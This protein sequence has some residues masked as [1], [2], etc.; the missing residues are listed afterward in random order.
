RAK[1]ALWQLC[2]FDVLWVGA[3]LVVLA[4]VWTW[5]GDIRTQPIDPQ[6]ADMLVVIR[7]GIARFLQWKNPYTIY[8]VPW[9]APLPYGPVLWLPFA[10][11][12]V[13]HV[14]IRVV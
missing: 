12:Y 7:E 6:R 13:L 4:T 3:A 10:I 1:H 8:H 2:V 5:F 11:P 14:D 9:D